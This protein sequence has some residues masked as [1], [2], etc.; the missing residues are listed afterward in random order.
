MVDVDARNV[1]RLI[2][3]SVLLGGAVMAHVHGHNDKEV[4]FVLL[5]GKTKDPTKVNITT[6]LSNCFYYDCKVI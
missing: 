4:H 6:C 2:A 5:L 1:N 3:N